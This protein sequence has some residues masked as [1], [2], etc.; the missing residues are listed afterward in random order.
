MMAKPDAIAVKGGRGGSGAGS[1]PVQRARRSGKAQEKTNAAIAIKLRDYAELL[2]QQGADGFRQ[3]AYSRAADVVSAL[4]RPLDEILRESGRDGLVTLPGIGKGIAGAIAEMIETGRWAQLERLR[5]EL[6][7][8]KLFRTIPGIGPELAARLAE[9]GHMET[10]EDLEAAL[11]LGALD[12]KGFGPRRRAM[13]AAALAQ[14]LGR[15][16][17]LRTAETPAPPVALL[18]EVDALYRKQAAAGSLRT[19]APKR[20]N[21]SG[22]AWLP[23]MHARHDDWHFTALYSN[24]LLAHQLDK[25]RDWVVIYY[26]LGDQPEGRCTVVT[27]TRGPNAGQRVVRGRE[28]E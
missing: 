9:D 13:I 5:G 16:L 28:S 19:I 8:E 2:T 10:L 6:A 17:A 15:P 4:E 20:F 7:P 14:R 21:P 25:T 26:H 23:I 12:V 24:T 27:E 11:H 18:L 1:A 22:E 3:R